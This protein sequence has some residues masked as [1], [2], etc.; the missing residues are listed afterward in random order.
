MSWPGKRTELFRQRHEGLQLRRF[1]GADRG[2]VHSV[3][4]GAAQQIF[5]HLLGDLE[6]HILLRLQRR[7]AEMRRA[8]HVGQ[9]EQRALRR[10]LLGEHVDGRAGDMAGF[11]R[12]HQC[13][14]V[15]EFAARAVDQPHALFGQLQRVRIDDVAGPVGERRVQRDEIGAAPQLLEFDLLDAKIERALGRQGYGS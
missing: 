13:R 7:S 14:L 3:G 11:Q 15:D 9:S 10:R 5:R 12:R 8:D 1:L 6:R 2:K 4:N